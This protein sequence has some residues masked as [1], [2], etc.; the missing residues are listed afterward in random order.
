[1]GS[2]VNQQAVKVVCDGVRV[3]EHLFLVVG[4]GAR[5]EV[6]SAGRYHAYLLAQVDFELIKPSLGFL[7][8]CLSLGGVGGGVGG[9][10]RGRGG[11]EG[12]R[13]G[14]EGGREGREGGREGGE[15]GREGGREGREGGGEQKKY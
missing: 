12:G 7:H 9:G 2:K 14:R 4:E 1:M 8:C 5:E 13:G 6:A 11:R 15:G 3:V 10:R